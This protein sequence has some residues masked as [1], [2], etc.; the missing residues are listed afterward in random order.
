[1]Q[2][3]MNLI[4]M[5]HRLELGRNLYPA[6]QQLEADFLALGR[7]AGRA[8]SKYKVNGVGANT[9]ERNPG[10]SFNAVNELHRTDSIGGA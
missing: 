4:L 5:S 9:L 8:D 1:M 10:A 7:C 6:L 3:E 2:G